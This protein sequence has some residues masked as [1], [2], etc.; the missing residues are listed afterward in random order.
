MS[1]YSNMNAFNRA[2]LRKD[3]YTET[4]KEDKARNDYYAAKADEDEKGFLTKLA[5]QVVGAAIGFVFGGPPG[6]SIGWKAGAPVGRQIQKNRPGY[7]EA[8]KALMDD[9]FTTGGKFNSRID[10]EWARTE[11]KALKDEEEAEVISD[12]LSIGSASYTYFDTDFDVDFGPGGKYEGWGD[13]GNKTDKWTVKTRAKA[14]K[15]YYKTFD[16]RDFLSGSENPSKDVDKVIDLAEGIVNDENAASKIIENVTNKVVQVNDSLEF[17]DTKGIASKWLQGSGNIK[18]MIKNLNVKD[19]L[20]NAKEGLKSAFT[21]VDT[22]KL[23]TVSLTNEQKFIIPESP[24]S[25]EDTVDGYSTTLIR[26]SDNTG[27]LISNLEIVD[28]ATKSV[29]NKKKSINLSFLNPFKDRDIID[30]DALF[31]SDKN[32]Y[33][34]IISLEQPEMAI[35]NFAQ[36]MTSLNPGLIGTDSSLQMLEA[37]E[38]NAELENDLNMLNEIADSFN[39]DIT[40]PNRDI[41]FNDMSSNIPSSRLPGQMAENKLHNAT[42]AEE[43]MLKARDAFDSGEQL[44]S[45]GEYNNLMSAFSREIGMPKGLNI[46]SIDWFNREETDNLPFKTVLSYFKK[47]KDNSQLQSF[48][49]RDKYFDFEGNELDESY[50]MNL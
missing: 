32:P 8:N 22:P 34:D 45:F 33:K 36:S 5:T 48:T 18:S 15:D 12:V 26:N 44:D 49:W 42:I 9:V 14:M 16:I 27:D 25:Y 23:D 43:V 4:A 10:K 3:Y 2:L 39:Q 6:A 30:W 35:P 24:F 29:R 13:W 46:D 19:I 38:S 20:S 31:N 50:E 40:L 7:F 41:T 28:N 47:F 37:F 21:P 17:N 11:Q 1:S